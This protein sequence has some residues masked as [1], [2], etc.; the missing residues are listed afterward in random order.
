MLTSELSGIIFWPT[1]LANSYSTANGRNKCIAL[2]GFLFRTQDSPPLHS[3]PITNNESKGSSYAGILRYALENIGV[4]LGFFVVVFIILI[5]RSTLRVGSLTEAIIWR[6][7][8]FYFLLGGP[9][10]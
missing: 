4:V 1:N 9:K 6:N 8:Y 5:P 10:V 7:G 3:H 2:S